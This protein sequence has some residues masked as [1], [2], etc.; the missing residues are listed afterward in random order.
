MPEKQ[1]NNCGGMSTVTM[2]SADW[3]RSE[4]RHETREKRL[5]FIIVVLVASL[6]LSN[7]AWLSYTNELSQQTEIGGDVINDRP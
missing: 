7:I 3:Q 1:C 6:L 2:S 4:Q 5:C